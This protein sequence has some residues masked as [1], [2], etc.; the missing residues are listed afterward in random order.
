MTP[1]PAPGLAFV[2]KIATEENYRGSG[3]LIPE[4]ARDKVSAEQWEIVVTGAGDPCDDEDCERWHWMETG[5]GYIGQRVHPCHVQPGDW[6]LVRKRAPVA[7]P[8]PDLWIIRQ[9]DVIGRFTILE[10]A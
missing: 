1:T 8:E 10:D 6:V 3:I 2:S 4:Q 9:D 7:S 5:P